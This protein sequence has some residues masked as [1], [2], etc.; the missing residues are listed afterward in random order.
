MSREEAQGHDLEDARWDT[1][2]SMGTQL[3]EWS[4]SAWKRI[5]DFVCVFC[6]LP[7]LLPLML[8]VALAVRITSAGPAFFL[9]KRMG[10][11]GHVF[12]IVKFRTMVHEKHSGQVVTTS[13]DHRF[14]PIGPFLRRWKLDEV[15]QLLNVLAGQMSLVGP[16]PKVPEHE[17]EVLHSRPG[18]TGAATIVFARE[19]RALDRIPREDLNAFYNSTVLPTKR[20]LDAAYMARATFSSDLMLI[21]KTVAGRWDIRLMETLLRIQGQDKQASRRR[22]RA[23]TTWVLPRLVPSSM[24]VADDLQISMD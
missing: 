18:V 1:E 11:N 24:R 16:R 23:I 21:L 4:D 17:P 15:P 19:E 5:F 10:R 2:V 20:Q 7:L 14:T 3:S 8:V 6:A 22:S 12:T 9:Q 13:S